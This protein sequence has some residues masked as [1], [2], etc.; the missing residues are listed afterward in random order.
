ADPPPKEGD[1][2]RERRI[3]FRGDLRKD[4]VCPAEDVAQLGKRFA[5]KGI[6]V[7]VN[8]DE[9]RRAAAG[10]SGQH[11]TAPTVPWLLMEGRALG[12]WWV[13]ST[14][15]AK[16]VPDAALNEA[17]TISVFCQKRKAA[18][19]IVDVLELDDELATVIPELDEGE[20]VLLAEEEDWNGHVY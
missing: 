13:G 12:C 16:L 4:I 17:G 11:W 1:G 18:R 7:C 19:Y 14:Q 6:P 15:S 10:K 9:L 8:F 5:Q 2:S 3:V 20:F